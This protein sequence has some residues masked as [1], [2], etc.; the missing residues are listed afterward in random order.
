MRFEGS[1]AWLAMKQ[2]KQ[3][4][5][6]EGQLDGLV[7]GKRMIVLCSFPIANSGA[8][9]LLGA[10]STHQFAIVRRQGEWEIVETQKAHNVRATLTR[11]EQ[12]IF[13][14]IAQGRS[15]SDIAKLL[16]ISKRTVDAHSQNVVQKLG[17]ANRT[18]AVAIAL[19]DGLIKLHSA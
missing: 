11:R 19:R 8:E 5:E 4:T 10:A 18:Q 15:A 13:T 2:A 12:E 7:A 16:C 14:W 17:A 9:Q 1:S 6:F 3:F